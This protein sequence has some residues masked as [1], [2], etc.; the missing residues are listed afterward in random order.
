[1]TCHYFTIWRKKKDGV[2]NTNKKTADL[3]EFFP[4]VEDR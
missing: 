1:M 4:Q 2:K 3:V